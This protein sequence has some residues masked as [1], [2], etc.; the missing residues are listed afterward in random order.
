LG[1]REVLRLIYHHMREGKASTALYRQL[2]E[3][4]G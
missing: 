2:I 4:Q 1:Y 3:E